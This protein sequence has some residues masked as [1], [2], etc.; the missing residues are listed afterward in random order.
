M[1]IYV[2]SHP[3]GG[4][5]SPTL[6]TTHPREN[7]IYDQRTYGKHYQMYWFGELKRMDLCFPFVMSNK[8]VDTGTHFDFSILVHFSFY[9]FL[10]IQVDSGC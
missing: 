10:G 6:G 9:D 7:Y 5:C 1:E 3:V 2:A 8:P 4:L